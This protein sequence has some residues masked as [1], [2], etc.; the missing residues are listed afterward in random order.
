VPLG[1]GGGFEAVTSIP[2]VFASSDCTVSVRQ[3]GLAALSL[4]G[5][6]VMSLTHSRYLS[7]LGHTKC[8]TTRADCTYCTALLAECARSTPYCSCEDSCLRWQYG[9]MLLGH[10][11][12][13]GSSYKLTNQSFVNQG[14]YFTEAFS[15]SSRAC[16]GASCAGKSQ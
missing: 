4:C 5:C 7:C 10:R 11:A 13:L 12:A 14:G 9:P 3:R 15:H 8:R 1:G 2:F 16:T 6:E